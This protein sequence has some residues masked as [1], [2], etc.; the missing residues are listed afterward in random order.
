MST[1]HVL[2]PGLLTT[3]QDRGRW[4]L[5][6][7]GVSVAGPMDPW[8]HRV[9]NAIVGNDPDASTLE[10]TLVG[11]ELEFD[12]DRVVAV[13]GAEFELTVSGTA[14][15][16]ERSFIVP[17]A[18]T[19]RFGKRIKGTRAY[20]SLA[21]GIHVPQTL[22]SR[23]THVVT[24]IGGLNGRALRAGDCLPLGIA[25][26]AVRA[27]RVVSR[28]AEMPSPETIIRILPGPQADRFEPD[29]LEILQSAPYTVAVDSDRMAFRLEGPTLKHSRGADVISDATPL[30][31]LQV[32]ASGKPILLMADRQTTGGYPKLAT[33][34]S[35]DICRAGQLAPGDRLSFVLCSQKEAIAALIAQERALMALEA[36]LAS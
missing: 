28:L 16:C 3:V 29:A 36:P 33:V 4:G 1:A 9:A 14:V 26:N 12:D 21:G 31:A 25:R 19:L 17:R 2:K 34:I 7:Y 6:A 13:A 15:S 11:P 24:G 27:G 5:Q 30:G 10:V 35:A 22:G 23:S 8:S 18:A 20:L 32:P